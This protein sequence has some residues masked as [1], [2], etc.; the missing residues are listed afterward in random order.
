MIKLNI[1]KETM[2]LLKVALSCLTI[3]LL[4]G[5][6]FVYG[7]PTHLSTGPGFTFWHNSAGNTISQN[8]YFGD[9]FLLIRSA[10]P[11]VY[12]KLMLAPNTLTQEGWSTLL[13]LA[14]TD[15]FNDPNNYEI[16]EITW[17]NNYAF[18]N[19][20]KNGTGEQRT[21]AF[22]LDA[23]PIL[24]LDI[25]NDTKYGD[26]N[27]FFI[28]ASRALYFTKDGSWSEPINITNLGTQ[29][30]SSV[31]PITTPA[32]IAK[33]PQGYNLVYGNNTFKVYC[34]LTGG[35]T[36]GLVFADFENDGD[37]SCVH[38]ENLARDWSWKTNN[39]LRINIVNL[40]TNPYALQGDI[41]LYVELRY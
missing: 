33:I 17:E 23:T 26:D 5:G 7:T 40:G 9:N 16:M 27:E 41:Y 21:L 11:G 29:K 32:F 39:E 22:M 28:W 2:R 31:N 35:N 19:V 8:E 37:Y 25:G 18:I 13:Q 20:F 3:G 14:N 15:F 34:T 38:V 6:L 10:V 30:G 36:A 4:I 24:K 1:K 12:T